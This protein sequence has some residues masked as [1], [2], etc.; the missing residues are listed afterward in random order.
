MNTRT[1][2]ALMTNIYLR[3]SAKN[4][5]FLRNPLISDQGEFALSLS[6]LKPCCTKIRMCKTML[7]D[8][9]CKTLQGVNFLSESRD[10]IFSIILASDKE[11]H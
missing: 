7:H 5:T 2:E 8:A 1:K 6:L 10:Q 11:A 4:Y 3:I 9:N